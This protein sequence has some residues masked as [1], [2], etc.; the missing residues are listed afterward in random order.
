MATMMDRREQ[1]D[2]PTTLVNWIGGILNAQ[3]MSVVL[4]G[5]V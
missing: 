1:K 2:N 3:E 5:E 4:K